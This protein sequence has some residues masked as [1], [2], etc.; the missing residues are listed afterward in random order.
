MYRKTFSCII[1]PFWKLN[2][3]LQD[4]I[5]LG[6]KKKDDCLFSCFWCE[7]EI[8]WNIIELLSLGTIY[9]A[10]KQACVTNKQNMFLLTDEQIVEKAF[11]WGINS[12]LNT[13]QVK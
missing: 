3:C 10:N 13:G 6:D 12:I 7:I 2:Y 1:S 5:H 11:C 4:L 9:I 8:F